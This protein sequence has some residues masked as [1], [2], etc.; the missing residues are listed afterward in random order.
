MT[1]DR[2]VSTHQKRNCYSHGLKDITA[3]RRMKTCA[4]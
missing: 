4:F 3:A 1:F 2:S